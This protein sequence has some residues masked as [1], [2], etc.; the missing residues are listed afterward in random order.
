MPVSCT[1]GQSSYPPRHPTLLNFVV[2][3]SHVSSMLCHRAWVPLSTQL[4]IE[5]ECTALQITILI[6]T[7]C[8]VMLNG[9]EIFC[10]PNLVQY[11]IYRLYTALLW[12]WRLIGN[13]TN[14][15]STTVSV[16]TCLMLKPL[17]WNRSA[18]SS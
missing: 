14:H 5:W 16:R 17:P 11:F 7:R 2:K 15:S 3:E 12:D 4:S 8:T 6:F 1:T 9:S 18:C 10:N 13:P